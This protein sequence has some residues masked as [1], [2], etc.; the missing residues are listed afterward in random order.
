MPESMSNTEI[1]DVLSSIRRLVTEDNRPLQ[2]P[3]ALPADKLVLTPA[4]RIAAPFPDAGPPFGAA[5]PL[6]LLAEKSHDPVASASHDAAA[7]P[8]AALRGHRDDWEPDAA[9]AVPTASRA[10]EWD[11]ADVDGSEAPVRNQH[12]DAVAE[13]HQAP[14]PPAERSEVLAGEGAAKDDIWD[15]FL[16][17]HRSAPLLAAEQAELWHPDPHQGADSASGDPVPLETAEDGATE[18]SA[19]T[20]QTARTESIWDQTPPEEDRGD[21]DLDGGREEDSS[22][23]ASV[24]ADLPDVRPEDDLSG[25]EPEED[26]SGLDEELLRDLLRDVLHEELQGELGERITRNLR[27]LVRAEIA[28]ALTARDLT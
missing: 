7:A 6:R 14:S 20:G 9:E 21:R 15:F 26:L 10:V 25:L 27:K 1:E 17:Q 11:A 28:R 3:D 22:W 23:P 2:R 18:L 13:A 12:D 24:P 5:E 16:A 4:L 8:E 19:W